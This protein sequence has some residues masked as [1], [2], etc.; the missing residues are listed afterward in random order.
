MSVTGFEHIGD[1]NE[2]IEKISLQVFLPEKLQ[3]TLHENLPESLPKQSGKSRYTCSIEISTMRPKNTARHAPRKKGM[4]R[5]F[6]GNAGHLPF[7]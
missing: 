1:I 4:Q 2:M 3:K 6:L 7:S 5:L